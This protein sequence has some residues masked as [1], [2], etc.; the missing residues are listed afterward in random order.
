MRLYWKAMTEG[1]FGKVDFREDGKWWWDPPELTK[2][3]SPQNGQKNLVEENLMGEGQKCP[4]AS[5]IWAS[6]RVVYV[7]V[8]VCVFFFFFFNS[9]F[10]KFF[11]FVHSLFFFL[12]FKIFFYFVFLGFS[13]LVKCFFCSH[14]SFFFLDVIFIF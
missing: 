13:T 7:C 14:S 4:C 11:I 8:C 5:C 3:I 12:F 10:N 6:V 1:V 2:K 9:S